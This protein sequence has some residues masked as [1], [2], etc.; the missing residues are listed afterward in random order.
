MPC[1]MFSVHILFLCLYMIYILIILK[2]RYRNI[3]QNIIS[4]TYQNWSPDI[5]PSLSNTSAKNLGKS[6]QAEYM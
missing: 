2:N 3:L 6:A 4:M 5:K 1:S